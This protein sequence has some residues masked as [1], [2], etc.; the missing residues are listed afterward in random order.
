MT[1]EQADEA[2]EWL[3]QTG[4]ELNARAVIAEHKYER[5]A[6]LGKQIKEM[7]KNQKKDDG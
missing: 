6:K 5:V 3:A 7:L 1:A 2:V 4:R